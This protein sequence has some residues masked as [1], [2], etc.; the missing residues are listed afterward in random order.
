MQSNNRGE[1]IPIL[2]YLGRLRPLQTLFQ[3]IRGGRKAPLIGGSKGGYIFLLVLKH[4]MTYV[5]FVAIR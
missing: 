3:V 1:D 4:L 5:L 2:A